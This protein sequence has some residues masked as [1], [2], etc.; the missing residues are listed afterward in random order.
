M[1]QIY[2]G[3]YLNLK[4]S[5][6]RKKLINM[7]LDKLNLSSFYE[8]FESIVFKGYMD[9]LLTPTEIGCF[10][11]H[12][13]AIKLSLS[14][15]T[16]IH[17]IEDDISFSKVFFQVVEHFI[18]TIDEKSWDIFFTSFTVPIYKPYYKFFLD[19]DENKVNFFNMS[20][21]LLTGA[22]SYIIN[23]HSKQKIIDKLEEYNFQIPVDLALRDLINNNY[24]KAYSV[25]PFISTHNYLDST[26]Q[27]ANME[28]PMEF[29]SISQ[30]VFYR[31]FHILDTKTIMINYA[32]QENFKISPMTN[33]SSTLNQVLLMRDFI[34]AKNKNKLN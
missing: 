26:I 20:N 3:L 19:Y 27:R 1:N 21:M 29:E 9:S 10:Q 24:L 18:K 13:E 5:T 17:I 30:R 25:Y 2:K 11:S 15:D 4:E 31:D 23:K 6:I 33:L 14:H 7:E 8:R 28:F 22:H 12:I 34:V 16:H 32:K